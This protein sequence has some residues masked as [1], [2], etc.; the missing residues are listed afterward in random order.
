MKKPLEILFKD[1]AHLYLGCKLA[2]PA[3]IGTL[4]DCTTEKNEVTCF[5]L[6][7][8][9]W[10]ID[11]VKP[12]LI[13]YNDL[14]DEQKE[15][16]NANPADFGGHDDALAYRVFT[17]IDFGVDLFR[18]IAKGEAIYAG[19]LKDG[20]AEVKRNYEAKNNTNG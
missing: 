8:S 5:D 18:L 20:L 7:G 11:D 2:T 3:G 6:V 1:V 17:L 14:T 15:K 16:A 13:H 9:Y 19:K 10:K 12:V 4:D